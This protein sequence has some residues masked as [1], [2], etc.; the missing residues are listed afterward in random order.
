MENSTDRDHDCVRCGKCKALCPTYNETADE[1]MSPRGRLMLLKALE[2][3]NETALAVLQKI[4]SCMLCGSCDKSCPLGVS[5]TS[6]IYE[7]RSNLIQLDK[8]KKLLSMLVKIVFQH[9]DLYFKLLRL[10]QRI[11]LPKIKNSHNPLRIIDEMGIEL[12]ADTLRREGMLYKS[13]RKRGRVALFLGCS[14]N[15]I[16]PHIGRQ[17][18]QTLTAIGYDIVVPS[19]EVCCGAPHLSVGLKKEAAINAEKN[20]TAFGKL[21]VEAVISLCPTCT[22]FLKNIYPNL[23]G[24]A[25]PNVMDI[26]EFILSNSLCDSLT[27]SAAYKNKKIMFHDPCHSLFKLNLKKEPREILRRSG[28]T[29]TEP[30]ERGCC[31]LAGAFKLLYTDISNSILEKR[32]DNYSDADLIVTSC[33][34]CIIQLKAG[35]KDKEI[36]HIAEMLLPNNS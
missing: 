31:G 10:L 8:N 20:I 16:Y 17:L 26:S 6:H 1:S 9:P 23:V 35:L 3:D 22:D 4:F 27:S 7:A 11:G 14:V 15:Y 30:R 24:A 29:L 28:L 34:N 19:S 25:M 12:A 2:Q 33:P 21:R 18:I 5:V 36:K 32:K 13:S